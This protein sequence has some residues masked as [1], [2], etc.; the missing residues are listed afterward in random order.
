MNIETQRMMIRHFTP[1]DA[2]DLHEIL[3]DDET[4]ENCEPAYSFEKTERFLTSF[5]MDRKGA[6]AAVHKESGKMVGYILFNEAAQGVYE[7]GWIYNRS[8]WRQD[9][10]Y[11]ACQAVIDYAFVKRKAHKIFAETIDDVKS[12]GLMQKLGMQ[13]EGVQRSQT[14]DNHG[15]WADLYLYGLLEDDWKKARTL[16]EP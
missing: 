16:R 3:G 10:A 5:C 9:Y 1:E 7:M 4:M 2:A 11:E 15:Q 12:V 13:L 14:K 8:F 6:V